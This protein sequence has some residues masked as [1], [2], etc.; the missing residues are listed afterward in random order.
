[1]ATLIFDE[2]NQAYQKFIESIKSQATRSIY[3]Y[4]LLK[5]LKYKNYNDIS[6]LI[7]KTDSK[8]IESDIIAYI[9][10]LRKVRKL[11]HST[12]DLYSSA[13]IQFY[14]IN[15]I[16]LNVKKINRYLGEYT[17]SVKDRAYTTE[18][19]HKLLEFCDERTNKYHNNLGLS[20]I[21]QRLL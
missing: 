18:E 14:L 10:Y 12:I 7:S 4:C 9:V 6:Q 15:D 5:Y 2:A 20:I 3:K 17:K 13:V 8:W 16:Q 19:I 21:W 11:S 1:M